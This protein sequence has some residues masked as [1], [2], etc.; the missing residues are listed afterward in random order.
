[1]KVNPILFIAC[2]L[3]IS[4]CGK[5]NE[6]RKE[7]ALDMGSEEEGSN[8]YS[9]E[10]LDD[11][12]LEIISPDAEISLL[13]TGFTWTEGPLWVEEGQ[14]LLFSDIPKNKIYKL[15]AAGDTSTYLQPSGYTG[16]GNYSNEPGS[17][18]LLFDQK[19]DLVL[20]Q[21][22]DRRIARM[23]AGLNAPKPDFETLVDRYN[24]KRFNSPNDGVFDQE[25]NLYFT[26]PPYGLPPEFIGK[27][28]DFQGVY[29]LLNS[30]ELLLL[31]SLS[32]PNGIA[33]SPKEDKLYVAVSDEKHAVWYQ[34]DLAG[35]GELS[36]KQVFY[37]V[38]DLIAPGGANGLPDGMEDHSQ[39]YLFATG[40]GGLWIFSPEGK[41]LARI[42]TGQLTSNCTFTADEK[43][44]Y[45]TAHHDILKVSLK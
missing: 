23:K 5:S 20:M 30:G 45:L 3:L 40:P 7:K 25:G 41:A 8:P 37:D 2:I 26:D 34:Y 43:Y 19:G 22:G 14:Y 13:A 9:V 18:G 28:L 32:R 1:M 29:C 15:D 21:H 16:E 11:E 39:G 44:L 17:N 31:D 38:T 35:P 42:H 33:L 27:E 36:N 10:I 24:G 4:A 12:A 6:S